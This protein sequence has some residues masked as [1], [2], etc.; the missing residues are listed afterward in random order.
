MR[1]CNKDLLHWKYFAQ[2]SVDY[3]IFKECVKHACF[4]VWYPR[5]CMNDL[6]RW[7]KACISSS[8]VFSPHSLVIAG[9]QFSIVFAARNLFSNDMSAP[10]EDDTLVCKI[11]ATGQCRISIARRCLAYLVT[12]YQY[13]SWADMPSSSQAKLECV[14]GLLGGHCGIP[15]AG[16]VPWNGHPYLT[17]SCIAFV[18][19]ILLI[20]EIFNRTWNWAKRRRK[21]RL[22]TLMNLLV[23]KTLL[24]LNPNKMRSQVWYLPFIT[25]FYL[26]SESLVIT[27]F[28]INLR[29]SS[30]V[31]YFSWI[32]KNTRLLVDLFG[33]DDS[34]P[35]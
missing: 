27:D 7:T 4:L 2:Y 28:L 6:L 22:L 13:C 5:L 20:F 35:E 8:V 25:S 3:D 21:R 19:S 18:A 24:S 29:V 23:V 34:L 16:Q 15:G 26:W 17:P 14:M 1:G 31:T 11:F 10:A 33:K 9:C 32:L 30:L 12:T